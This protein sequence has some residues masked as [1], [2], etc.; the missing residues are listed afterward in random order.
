M[1]IIESLPFEQR[2][3]IPMRPQSP[4]SMTWP[5]R[6]RCSSTSWRQFDYAGSA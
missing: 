4:S 5:T 6:W 3:R 2:L 1:E